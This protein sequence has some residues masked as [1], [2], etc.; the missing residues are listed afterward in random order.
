MALTFK[1]SSLAVQVADAVRLEIERGTW[2]EWMPS[3]R[4]LSRSLHVSRNTCRLALSLLYRQR[5]VQPVQGR[6]N[7]VMDRPLLTRLQAVPQVHSVGVILPEGLGRTRP[8]LSLIIEALQR[9]LYD[10]QVRTQ[11]HSGPIY[12]AG[13]PARALE[14]LVERNPHDCWVLLL[15]NRPLQKWFMERGLPCIVG[16]SVYSEIELPSVDFDFRAVCRH[17]T[18]KLLALGH[19]RIVFFNRELRGAGDLES[20]A[21]F[22]EAIKAS[23]HKKLDARIV[24]HSDQMATVAQLIRHMYS[25]TGHSP[26]RSARRQF[27]QLSLGDEYLGRLRIAGALRCQFDFARRR[28]VSFPPQSD[29]GPLPL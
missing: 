17:A 28:S 10:M 11:L 24:Y 23:S 12:Y 2:P 18:G 26:T 20:E 25:G 6:G 13:N 3:E 5:L 22:Q 16:G 1:R 29:A 27:F 7:R 9:E 15:S 14:K 4:D 8:T 19:Q 21:G